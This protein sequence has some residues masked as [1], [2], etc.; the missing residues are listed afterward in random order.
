MLEP[1]PV[2]QPRH[3]IV[4]GSGRS[5]PP[6]ES[7][8]YASIDTDF[9]PM[10][11]TWPRICSGFISGAPGQSRAGGGQNDTDTTAQPSSG[12]PGL[13]VRDWCIRGGSGG[14]SRFRPTTGTDNLHVA[15]RPPTPW[16]GPR[17]VRQRGTAAH[18][19]PDEDVLDTWF[20][21][22]L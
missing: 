21:S 9:E 15:S 7:G 19:P 10:V 3:N 6:G 2:L 5:R 14:A 8:E 17:A 18:R 22:W 12:L 11:S 20:S 4:K 16:R 1:G 13:D